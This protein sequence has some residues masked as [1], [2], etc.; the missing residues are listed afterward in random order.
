[1]PVDDRRRAPSAAPANASMSA[2]MK[3]YDADEQPCTSIMVLFAT[4]MAN[5][6]AEVASLIVQMGA[7]SVQVLVTHE[8]AGIESCTQGSRVKGEHYFK[9][10]ASLLWRFSSDRE[11][12]NL[13]AQL[14]VNIA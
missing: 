2:M 9:Q 10:S 5:T 12:Q 8:Q 6:L 7:Q 14:I 3:R 1:M 13:K 4:W 11:Q